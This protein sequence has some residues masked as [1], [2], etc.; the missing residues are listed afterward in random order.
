MNVIINTIHLL[1]GK[2]INDPPF[3]QLKGDKVNK[4]DKYHIQDPPREKV[5]SIEKSDHDY[6]SGK[7]VN[8]LGKDEEM[9]GITNEK[10]ESKTPKRKSKKNHSKS[11]TTAMAK[12]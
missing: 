8:I 6:Y 4:F 10:S 9:K 5:H 12:I 7:I 11:N 3:I 2:H 1:W